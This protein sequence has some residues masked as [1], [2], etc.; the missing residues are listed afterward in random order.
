MLLP[1]MISRSIKNATF[2]VFADL[3]S[4]SEDHFEVAAVQA[5]PSGFSAHLTNHASPNDDSQSRRKFAL[6][7][8]HYS[9]YDGVEWASQTGGLLARI[10]FNCMSTCLRCVTPGVAR[11]WDARLQH[12]FPLTFPMATNR[13]A[14]WNGGP[15]SIG[16]P[17]PRPSSLALT[18]A[19]KRY[20]N[21][22]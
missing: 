1:W 2:E 13:C 15:L 8:F 4:G 7:L 14:T 11:G 21:S 9:I 3:A 19:Q 6:W 10:H 17:K 22:R 20:P 18:H 12:F 16:R 5:V